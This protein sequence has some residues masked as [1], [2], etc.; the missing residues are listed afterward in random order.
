MSSQSV[1]LLDFS[2][3]FFSER[4][5]FLNIF[6]KTWHYPNQRAKRLFPGVLGSS[7]N[8]SHPCLKGYFLKNQ[9]SIPSTEGGILSSSQDSLKESLVTLTGIVSEIFLP[10]S[11]Y[12][13]KLNLL[14]WFTVLNFR[15]SF[16]FKVILKI[17]SATFT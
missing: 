3:K 7:S 13:R 14:N 17:Y 11:A 4:A 5:A 16:L 10:L 12:S 15:S 9:E 1:L 2:H 6:H 8:P